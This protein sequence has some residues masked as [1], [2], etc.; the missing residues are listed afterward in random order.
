V[1]DQQPARADPAPEYI[2]KAGV[3]SE[4]TWQHEQQLYHDKDEHETDD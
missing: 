1:P 3:P 2:A 4:A